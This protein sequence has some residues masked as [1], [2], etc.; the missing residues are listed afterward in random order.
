MLFGAQTF[1]KLLLHSSQAN[2][3]PL[4]DAAKTAAKPAYYKEDP[5]SGIHIDVQMMINIII[6]YIMISE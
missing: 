2:P 3:I 6:K 4:K 1:F 5:D